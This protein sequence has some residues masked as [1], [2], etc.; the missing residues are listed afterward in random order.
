MKK[1][2][3]IIIDIIIIFVGLIASKYILKGCL[4]IID[5][6]NLISDNGRLGVLLIPFKIYGVVLFIVV[7]YIIK[8]IN[9]KL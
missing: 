4:Y 8:L 1:V 7:P 9:A 6:F 2:I 5:T 3:K